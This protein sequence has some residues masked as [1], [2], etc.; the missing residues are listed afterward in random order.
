MF[1]ANRTAIRERSKVTLEYVTRY[2]EA[3]IGF[4]QNE[5]TRRTGGQII[6]GYLAGCKASVACAIANVIDGSLQLAT[7]P[8]PVNLLRRIDNLVNGDR[9]LA[10]L[11]MGRMQ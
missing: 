4:F 1:Q 5:L 2:E 8:E 3:M 7:I 10:L 9:F 11:G 6:P